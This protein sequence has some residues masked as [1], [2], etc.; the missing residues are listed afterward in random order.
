MKHN[1]IISLELCKEIAD[2][3]QTQYQRTIIGNIVNGYYLEMI[4]NIKIILNSNEKD[5]LDLLISTFKSLPDE[6]KKKLIKDHFS[7][8]KTFIV[9]NQIKQEESTANPETQDFFQRLEC[10]TNDRKAL[11]EKTKPKKN[12]AQE[13]FKPTH[14]TT[15]AIDENPKEDAMN[16][17]SKENPEDKKIMPVIKTQSLTKMESQVSA[18]QEEILDETWTTQ[19]K[20]REKKNKKILTKTNPEPEI[21][22]KTAIEEPIKSVPD[23]SNKKIEPVPDTSNIPLSKIASVR[24]FEEGSERLSLSVHIKAPEDSSTEVAHKSPTEIEFQNTPD[25]IKQENISNEPV[26]ITFGFF[27]STTKTTSPTKNEA[28]IAKTINKKSPKKIIDEKTKNFMQSENI[29]NNLLR[30]TNSAVINPNIILS[31]TLENGIL[32]IVTQNI[33]TGELFQEYREPIT[34]A[35]VIPS[36]TSNQ[37]NANTEETKTKTNAKANGETKAALAEDNAP[38]EQKQI[39][40]SLTSKTAKEFTLSASTNLS[41]NMAKQEEKEQYNQ[42]LKEVTQRLED[43]AAKIKVEEDISTQEI[44]LFDNLNHSSFK[45]N[46]PLEKEKLSSF[47]FLIDCDPLQGNEQILGLDL[48]KAINYNYLENIA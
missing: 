40:Y 43:Q 29:A 47:P 12:K 8:I 18:S 28:I 27:D 10:E 24:E 41:L 11:R 32:R 20:K 38:A 35:L 6:L 14:S 22:A 17:I 34:G 31:K 9:S 2:T 13:Q 23:T 45:P 44:S 42:A 4:E 7:K 46:L 33:I 19:L 16:Q 39:N 21:S 15:S 30:A 26:E 25:I 5:Q 36:T 1:N 37:A 48:P 3:A